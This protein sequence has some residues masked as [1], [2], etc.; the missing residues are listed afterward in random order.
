[1]RLPLYLLLLQTVVF[2]ASGQVFAQNP[3]V[4]KNQR[5]LQNPRLSRLPLA[6]AAPLQEPLPLV[7]MIRAEHQQAYIAREVVQDQKGARERIIKHH[8]T[9][10]T[11]RESV[12]PPGETLLD[13]YQ[14]TFVIT[15]NGR[16][17]LK[18]TSTY[19][20]L[21]KQS[22]SFL[23]KLQRGALVL[24][25]QGNDTIVGRSTDVIRIGPREGKLGPTWRL[26]LDKE[27]GLRLRLEQ[28]DPQ[29]RIIFSAY[30]VSIDLKPVFTAQDFA[31]P[32]Q[33]GLR[34]ERFPTIEAAVR[35]GHSV[36]V[37]PVLRDNYRLKEVLIAPKKDRITT[38]WTAGMMT[39][40]LVQMRFNQMPP[41]LARQFSEQP[42]YIGEKAGRRRGYGWRRGE[43]A[44]LLIGD[45]PEE[46]L[47]R[48]ADSR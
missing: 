48:I 38:V 28:Q 18:E 34:P 7:R 3:K 14:N 21:Q 35:A 37:P 20:T 29:G 40:S 24:E 6:P 25:R 19:T 8:P 13:N 4:R 39:I 45:L 33:V 47:R 1:M 16:V 32:A 10:G 43:F 9:R 31:V 17:N 22:E 26:W 5:V 46:D 12:V 23:Q 2:L 30:Y 36:Q 15:P 27:T 42:S 44:F 11:R 41:A